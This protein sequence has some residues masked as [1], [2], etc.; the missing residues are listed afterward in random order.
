V[1]HH[2]LFFCSV[3][4][5]LAMLPSLQS[6]VR[7]RSLLSETLRS[8]QNPITE[9][10]R[11]R[12]KSDWVEG[13][14]D[15]KVPNSACWSKAE[16]TDG[17]S[18]DGQQTLKHLPQ[19]LLAGIAER[20]LESPV[21]HA[22]QLGKTSA[23]LEGVFSNEMLWQAFLEDRLRD[24]SRS[25]SPRFRPK[26]LSPSYRRSYAKLHSLEARFCGGQ[27]AARGSLGNPHQGEA[28]LDLRVG[29]AA[30]EIGEAEIAFAALRNGTIMV[31]DLDAS[32]M[33]MTLGAGPE[34]DTGAKPLRPQ[35]AA[36]IQELKPS[37]HGGPALCC[38]P[39]TT[40]STDGV[41]NSA[42]PPSLLVAGYA[43]GRLGAWSLPDG[44]CCMPSTWEAAHN[45]R[46]A[47]L[48]ARASGAELLSASS[49]GLIKAWSL[50]SDRF[51]EM[52][53]SFPGHSAA[54]V[55]VA[56][57]PFD[58]GLFLS[59]SHDRT[60][61]LWD[62]RQGTDGGVVAQWRQNEWVTGVDFSPVVDTHIFSSNK[63]VHCWDMRR[64]GSGPLTSTHRHR[65]LVSRF[66]LDPMRLASCSLDGCVKVSSLEE[67][68]V[69]V[70]SPRLSPHH[71]PS[72]EPVQPPPLDAIGDGFVDNSEVCTLR[73]SADY[74]LCVDFDATRLLVGGVDGQVAVYD[75]SEQ[76]YFRSTS[77]PAS[78]LFSCNETRAVD[79]EMTGLQDL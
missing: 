33:Q 63:S 27:Y 59:G 29:S 9:A 48:T 44:S 32:K 3:I 36:P 1:A 60:M 72:L 47:A 66:R 61:R 22:C 71:S 65:K 6:L 18:G 77:L 38:V 45:G 28:V 67:P 49:D 69:R 51:G 16:P 26:A 34:S 68:G 56:A 53:T 76:D 55:S 73:T 4:P 54:V 20:F 79:I 57:S 21:W 62:P 30:N 19:E 13:C 43:L 24:A 41:S 64:P 37:T 2:D 42:G 8:A 17:T 31:Y 52:S 74:V 25:P 15:G 50:G 14:L 46:V 78:S 23:E 7:E 40:F 10:R 39:I 11:V 58:Q 35:H 75:F 70:A 5:V 12:G